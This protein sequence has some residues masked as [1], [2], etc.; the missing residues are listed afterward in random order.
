VLQWNRFADLHVAPSLRA[1]LSIL[2]AEGRLRGASILVVDD[3]PDTQEFL[4][5][6]LRAEGYDVTLASDGDEATT[7]YQRQPTDLVL[8]DIFLPSKDGIQTI[9]ELR[10][11]F[12]DVAIIA[13]SA[14]SSFGRQNALA[15]AR[16][17]G[18]AY[19]IRKPLEPW[20]LL[21]AIEGL[22]MARR[23]PRDF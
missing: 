9:V 2:L 18:V 4:E 12:R 1:F 8:L 11:Q 22:V 17:A 6:L 5:Y 21:R 16:E 14:D 3:H 13:M 10:R 20:V 23:A 15:R 19:T 7:L